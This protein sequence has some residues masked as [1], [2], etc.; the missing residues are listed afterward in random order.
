MKKELIQ[1]YLRRV[2]RTIEKERL[3]EKGDKIFVALSGGKDSASA[4]IALSQFLKESSLDFEL[5]GF[6][7]NLDLQNSDR[8]EKVV[9]KQAK[10]ASVNLLTVNLKDVGIDL[11]K[12]AKNSNRPICSVCGIVKRRLM[13]KIPRENGATKVATGHHM[14][15]FIVFFFKNILGR[16]FSWIAKFKPKIESTHPKVLCKIRPLFYVGGK[17]NETFCKVFKI[18]FVPEDVCPFSDLK[19]KVEKKR[20]YELIYEIEE[21]QKD[22][23]FQL[24]KSIEKMSDFFESKETPIRECSICGE[25]TNQEICA[26]C[27]LMKKSDN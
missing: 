26:F 10:M 14:D 12:L 23:R 2:F 19:A 24:A 18:P 15:D 5:K 20:W 21:W 9:R 13:N 16:N 27:K 3:V 22:F 8:I 25:P 6:H 17:E 4:L 1:P 11:E 7:I